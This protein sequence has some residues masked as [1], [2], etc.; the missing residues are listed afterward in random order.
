MENMHG[1]VISK[2]ICYAASL[3]PEVTK[4]HNNIDEAMRLGFNWTMG[5]FEILETLKDKKFLEKNKNIN[6]SKF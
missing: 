4:E 1:S 3:I 5:P 6:L 2:I